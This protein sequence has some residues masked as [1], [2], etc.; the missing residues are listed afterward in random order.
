MNKVEPSTV[1]PEGRGAT[2]FWNKKQF[3][4]KFKT[5]IKIQ[6]RDIKMENVRF[7]NISHLT[8]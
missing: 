7:L 1:F 5:G 8:N 3:L 6:Q 4:I 2:S